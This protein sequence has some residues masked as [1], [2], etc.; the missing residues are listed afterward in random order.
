VSAI[1]EARS[2]STRSSV[3]S[4][5]RRRP[6]RAAFEP[7]QVLPLALALAVTLVAALLVYPAKTPGFGEAA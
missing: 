7:E 6:W 3:A 4:R 5:K 2:R 1:L